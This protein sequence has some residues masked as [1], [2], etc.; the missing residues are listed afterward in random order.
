M[1][2]GSSSVRDAIAEE[3]AA[4]FVTLRDPEGGDRAS[5]DFMGWL[6]QSPLHVEEYLRIASTQRMLQGA[7]AALSVDE[8]LATV[9]RERN[10]TA[11]RPV[12]PAPEHSRRPSAYQLAAAALIAVV[13]VS[14][15]WLL[16]RD[17]P[18]QALRYATAHGESRSWTLPDR[19]VV[20]LDTDS[21]IHVR[22][23]AGERLVDVDR[24]RANFQVMRDPERRFRVA[25][26]S[27]SV[28][29]TGTRFDVDR[30]G[31]A[32]VV[33]LAEGHV[34]LYTNAGTGVP[35]QA[36]RAG[37]RAT[38]ESAAVSV[39]VEVDLSEAEAWRSGKIVFHG[40]PVT[41]VAAQ[42]NRYAPLPIE[43]EDATLGRRAI[44][45]SFDA[46]DID[47]FVA[48]L[49]AIGGVVVERRADRILIHGRDSGTAESVGAQR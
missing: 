4:W 28:V 21:E 39:P 25:A 36:L 24:G 19:S 46:R 30:R 35:A 33:T 34:A 9:V 49:Q 1:G 12:R 26:G 13:A 20:E 7:G 18:A 38:I 40:S 32:V 22:Y 5:V 41:D 48:Y 29:A 31:S 27:A 10:V 14:A 3:A 8:I 37:E 45:G 2:A 42:F 17:R 23:A 44:S 47:S 43:I 6:R 11:I 15:T 16:V